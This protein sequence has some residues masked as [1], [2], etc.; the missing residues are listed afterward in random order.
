MRI[1]DLRY[2]IQV[3][4][5]GSIS[6]VAQTHYITQQGLS[7]II[8][9]LEAELDVKLLYRGKTMR[10][11]PAGKA[12]LSDAKTIEDAYL[13]MLDTA[14]CMSTRWSNAKGN[15]YT[16][17]ATPVICATI[18]GEI[19]S[20]LNQKFPGM[21][22]NVLER[23][24]MVIVDEISRLEKP[25]PLSIAILSISDFLEQESATFQ[26]GTLQFEQLFTDEL[27]VGVSADS[28]F[29]SQ[30]EISIEQ[31]RELPLVLHNSE[32]LMVE[33]LLGSKNAVTHTTNHSFCR[34]MIAQG[35]AVGLTSD[36]IQYVYQDD[37]VPIPFQ[38]NEKV[39]IK[40]G[41]VRWKGEDP[42]VEEIAKVIRATFLQI[43]RS[44]ARLNTKH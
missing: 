22:F 40:Y 10:L 37:I 36:I 1:E 15:I 5:A 2:F 6:Q 32:T 24:C 41:I 3:S 9:S 25:N 44:V 20:T 43:G 7:R 42:F 34:E 33:H 14:N 35:R 21:F 18:L 28:P 19:I 31:L 17:Y 39:Q 26:N 30:S 13:R 38:K 8:S 23:N 16:I 12:L 29:A 27:C 11:T 4:E